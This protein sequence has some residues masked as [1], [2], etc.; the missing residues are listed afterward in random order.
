MEKNMNLVLKKE[1]EVST[2][3]EKNWHFYAKTVPAHIKPDDLNRLIFNLMRKPNSKFEN[4]EVKAMINFALDTLE[5]GYDPAKNHVYP[6]VYGRGSG[7]NKTYVLESQRGYKGVLYDLERAGI[8]AQYA[9]VHESELYDFNKPGLSISHTPSRKRV[10]KDI[11]FKL[12]G[13]NL[14]WETELDL[15]WVIYRDLET[16]EILDI[17]QMYIDDAIEHGL[18]FTKA[19]PTKTKKWVNNAMKTVPMFID[20]DNNWIK[21]TQAMIIKTALMQG[22]K[23]LPDGTLAKVKEMNNKMHEDNVRYTSNGNRENSWE[24]D[25][26]SVN[27]KDADFE[28]VDD[29][30]TNPPSQ[31]SLQLDDKKDS[32]GPSY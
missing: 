18:K 2:A 16:K 30:K 20:F 15:I 7:A 32:S 12:E 26:R 6:I 4:L 19:S 1:Q 9:F 29:K 8:Y 5:A 10:S 31:P 13:K 11:S 17:F 14:I 28:E 23:A 21:N 24:D 3:I 22:I 25:D 27:I